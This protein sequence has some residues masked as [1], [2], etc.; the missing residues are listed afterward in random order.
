[1]NLSTWENASPNIGELEDIRRRTGLAN[2]SY[3]LLFAIMKSRGVHRQTKI[4]LRKT[5]I[6]SI[7]WYGSKA[8]I[9]SQTAE[10]NVHCI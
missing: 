4:K 8:W 1:M 10:K 6:R 2:S 5:L 7:L 3:H 9:L